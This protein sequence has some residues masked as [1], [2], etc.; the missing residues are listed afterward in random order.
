MLI[1]LELTILLTFMSINIETDLKEILKNLENKLDKVADD[2]SELKTD[3]AVLKANQ[4]NIKEQLSK[5][6]GTQKAQIWSLIT[7]VLATIGTLT[8][9]LFKM[10]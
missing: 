6:D 5:I 3:T 2:V 1:F 4:E 8:V 9:A 10:K 7:L